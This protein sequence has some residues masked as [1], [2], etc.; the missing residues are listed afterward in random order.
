[1]NKRGWILTGILV[2]LLGAAGL[3]RAGDEAPAGIAGVAAPEG[4]PSTLRLVVNAPAFRLEVWERGE[5]TRTFPVAIGKPSHRTPIGNYNISHIDWNPWWHPPNSAWARNARPTPPG[6]DNPMGRAKL[7]FRNLYYIHGS[8][9]AETMG[10]A[11]SHGCIR[12]TN[13]DVVEL[14]R[15]VHR[16]AAPHVSAELLRT[17][18]G[19]PRGTRQVRMRPAVPLEI[20]YDI[21]EV[22]DG[23]LKLHPDVYNRVGNAAHEHA[24]QAL[25]QEG[26][27]GSAVD[28]ERL[29][30]LV[31]EGRRVAVSVPVQDVLRP[32]AAAAGP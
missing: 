24:V 13:E 9:A 10:A 14:G 18:I 1:M 2:G 3:W 12:M 11:A 20:R 19:N 29:R 7:Y 8:P 26:Y 22:V 16:H 5:L 28:T 31:R 21:A 25:I 6:P 23:A 4:P 17:I 27:D 15:I 32:V 30:E